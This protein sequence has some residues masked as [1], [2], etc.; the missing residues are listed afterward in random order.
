LSN[1]LYAF[2]RNAKK[3]TLL[4]EGNMDWA[5]F[6]TFLIAN[7][8]FTLILWLWNRSESNADRREM[9]TLFKAIAEEMKDFH[10]RLERQD[11]EFRT[12]L[13]SIEEKRLSIFNK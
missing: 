6:G 2:E 5:Q 1:N 7:I 13:L 12:R 4:A 3:R 11:A 10:G 9:L 8:A